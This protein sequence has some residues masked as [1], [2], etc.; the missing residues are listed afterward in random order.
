[1]VGYCK[2]ITG[3]YV[4]GAKLRTF[5]TSN[6]LLSVYQRSHFT[7][8]PCLCLILGEI[9]VDQTTGMDGGKLQGGPLYSYKWSYNSTYRLIGGYNPGYL[10]MF[11]HL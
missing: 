9:Y 11:G 4:F 7:I 5:A 6:L 8:G 2:H 10:F 3:R 1:M